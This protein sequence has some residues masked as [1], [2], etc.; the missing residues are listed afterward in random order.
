MKLHTWLRLR[1][2]ISQLK[3]GNIMAIFYGKVIG[4]SWHE[5]YVEVNMKR[6]GGFN[7]RLDYK[8]L[9]YSRED[10]S[11]SFSEGYIIG[12]PL[13]N[14]KVKRK[15]YKARVFGGGKQFE[16]AST[17]PNLIDFFKRQYDAMSF[18]EKE[19]F[20]Y[21]D[22]RVDFSNSGIRGFTHGVSKRTFNN[23]IEWNNY[24]EIT[25]NEQNESEEIVSG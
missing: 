19:V 3:K 5:K 21:G 18:M 24:E 16:V 2:I 17:N 22:Y 6:K 13:T 1:V 10:L 9:P 20:R 7:I 25:F 23:L 14:R 8:D 12:H 15:V 11:K 4:S